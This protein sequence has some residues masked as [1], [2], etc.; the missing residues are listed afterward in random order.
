MQI[1]EKKILKVLTV[2]VPEVNEAG[3][4]GRTVVF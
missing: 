1:S 3:S 2:A 4:R